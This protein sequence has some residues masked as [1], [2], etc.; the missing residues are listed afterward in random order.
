[1]LN[2]NKETEIF[3][4]I[5]KLENLYSVSNYGNVFS[6]RS[7]KLLSPFITKRGYALIIVSIN[8][9]PQ[10]LSIHRLVAETFIPQNDL[11]KVI[12]NHIDGNKLNNNAT[13]LEW[14]TH[15]ENVQHA[16][17]T[18]LA[19]PSLNRLG[20]KQD[21]AISKYN[22]VT[23]RKGATK[24]WSGSIKYNGKRV[25]CKWFYTEIE[26]A[27]HVNWIYDHLGI[28]NRPKNIIE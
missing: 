21:T 23:Y 24:P 10:K 25:H 6:I 17:E 3:I 9:K 15:K 11:H 2:L 19:T 26:A 1:M 4:P 16:I 18:N 7:N 20:G 27:L 8:G 12:V 13:N 5:P 22:N 28:T 14:C